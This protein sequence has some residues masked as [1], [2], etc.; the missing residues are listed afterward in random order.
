MN[1]TPQNGTV[2]R[3]HW[4]RS[5]QNAF[6]AALLGSGCAAGPDYKKP[7]SVVPPDW[8]W[9]VAQPADPSLRSDWWQLFGDPVLNDLE[10]RATQ[11]NPGLQ[12]AVARVDQSRAIA[13]LDTSEFFPQISFNPSV[14]YFQTAPTAWV[15]P[16]QKTA[17]T[18]PLDLSYEV[19]LWGKVR[20]SLE[21][22][23]SEAQANVADYY[24]VL[25]T[26][27]GDVAVNYFLLRQLD[28]QTVLLREILAV[29]EKCIRL[30]T[31]RFTSG[32]TSK[33][34][35]DR[36]LV[37]LARAR[38]AVE[39][40]ERQRDE[41]QHAL[42][43][44]C[45]EPAGTFA[46][47]PAP[48]RSIAP[49]IPMGLPST[50]LE[51]RPDVAEAE[52]RMAAANAQIGVAKAAFFPAIALTGAAGYSSFEAGSLLNW[53]SRFFQ[54]GPSMSL[55]L[56]NG[57]RL[58]SQISG[59]RAAY[60]AACADY[61]AQILKAFQEVTDSIVSQQSY[62]QQSATQAEAVAATEHLAGLSQE[63]YQSGLINYL[64]VLDSKRIQLQTQF[65]WVQ[66]QALQWVATVH[67]VKA[68]GGG[69]DARSL[70][71]KKGAALIPALPAP[72]KTH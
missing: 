26:L 48:L 61:Q 58:K 59:A 11:A 33:I 1:L 53:E 27:H 38:N 71:P 35:L 25:L 12:V 55:P 6:L 39:E 68:L 46:I 43:V 20:R 51:R 13:R 56:L 21:S 30:I 60:R 57:G 69:F 64:E 47:A 54:F 37:E 19:D 22:A 40:I 29:R 62:G 5:I 50:L 34:D 2:I 18:L 52:R 32:L 28:S 16:L 41:L 10:A 45:G 15:Y 23:R 24:Q 36:D 66:L 9:K 63:R 44:L 7:V 72:D 70:E 4:R 31:E 17:T 42:A 3:P 14:T 8:G 65:Q 49:A 67:L